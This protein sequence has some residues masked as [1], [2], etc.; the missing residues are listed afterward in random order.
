MVMVEAIGLCKRF[1]NFVALDQITFALEKGEIVGLIGPNGAG[2]STTLH[3]LLGLISRTSGAL[4]IFG[5]DPDVAREAVFSRLNFASPYVGFPPRLSVAENLRVYAKLYGI[6]D[7]AG[8]IARLLRRLGCEHLRDRLS[9]RL[10]SG[11]LSRVML[12]KAL[13]NDPALLILDEPAANLDPAAAD[14][15]R[16][17]LEERRSTHGTT[18]LLTSHNLDHVEQICDRLLLLN[19]GRIQA[20]GS[21]LDV[22]RAVLGAEK[23]DPA[24]ADVFRSLAGS[25]RPA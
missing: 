6:A 12:C 24:L 9:A 5:Q 4:R 23:G 1:D 2:K 10:S 3:L 21:A 19:H 7:P 11:E 15:I 14:E 18:I 8:T 17:I 16:A 22:T 13:L 20:E 25:S